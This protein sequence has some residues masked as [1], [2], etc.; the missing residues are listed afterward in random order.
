MVAVKR[1][2]AR[3]VRGG[4]GGGGRLCQECAMEGTDGKCRCV[5]EVCWQTVVG[6]ERKVE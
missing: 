2:G 4:G 3:V 1:G 6:A 5:K